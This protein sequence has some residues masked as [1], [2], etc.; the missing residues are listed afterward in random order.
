MKNN[1]LRN[2]A[3]AGIAAAVMLGCGGSSDSGTT[4]SGSTGITTVGAITGFGSVFVNGVEYETNSAE[5]EVEDESAFDDSALKVG[6]VVKVKGSVNPDGR[7]GTANQIIYEDEIEGPV[8]ELAPLS[9]DL[10][11][12]KV[13]GVPIT[14][15]NSSTFFDKQH[16]VGFS[17]DTLSNDDHVE[18]SGYFNGQTLQATYIKKEDALDD[19]FEIK[20][21]ITVYDAS[22]DTY[23][24][25]TLF[26]N[27]ITFTLA[28]NV[29]IPQ[30]GQYVEVEGTPT[31]PTSLLAF[32]VELEDRH[33]LS[34]DEGEIEIF[35]LLTKSADNWFLNDIPLVMT[36]NIEYEPSALENTIN[37]L[38]PEGVMVKVEGEYRNGVLV[39]DEIDNKQDSLELKGEVASI[40][41]TGAKTGTLTIA[42][43]NAT[44]TVTVNLDNNTMYPDDNSMQQFDLRTDVH[45][46]D[47]VEV[48][49]MQ[50]QG[51]QITAT[52]FDVDDSRGEYEVEGPLDNFTDGSSITAMNV[53][54]TVDGGTVYLP[55]KPV[56]NDL[57]D[58]T[59]VDRDGTADTVEI[60]D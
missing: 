53:T 1:E 44:G 20:G 9:T 35:G 43:G 47:Y 27:T 15:S 28:A 17:F 50:D 26:G 4:A 11:T 18:V 42:F 21:V 32:K 56:S 6:M 55:R 29:M 60:E 25:D 41:A 5:Y 48:K 13:F 58:I 54:F 22:S 52:L 33:H 38:P 3:L 49:A 57:V 39:V 30:V 59:D 23:T 36:G 10:K 8:Q 46:G 45:T 2:F 34:D 19:D 16:D 24:L 37:N 7:T 40:S 31:G 12:F 51:G 14:V